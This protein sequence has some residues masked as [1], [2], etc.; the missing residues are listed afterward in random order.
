MPKSGREGEAFQQ[1]AT[2]PRRGMR[3]SER[4][5]F[6]YTIDL[7][8]RKNEKSK[9]KTQRTSRPKPQKTKAK[10]PAAKQRKPKRDSTPV[11]HKAPVSPE[12]PVQHRDAYD[13]TRNNTTERRE[14]RRR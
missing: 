14:Y 4:Q 8:G 12:K 5:L 6:Q 11:T 13:E 9:A 3:P 7:T 2:P 10:P 1:S